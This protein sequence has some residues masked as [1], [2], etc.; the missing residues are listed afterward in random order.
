MKLTPTVSGCPV[1]GLG[2]DGEVLRFTG[3]AHQGDGSDGNT[4]VDNGN[5]QFPLDG[6]AGGHQLFR[7]AADLVVDLL[8][9]ALGVGIGAVQQA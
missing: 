7:M 5:T 1:H 6:F 3:S 2:K 9:A 4:L 8:G